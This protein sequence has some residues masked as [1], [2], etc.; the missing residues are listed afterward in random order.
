MRGGVSLIYMKFVHVFLTALACLAIFFVWSSPTQAAATLC[1]FRC[2]TIRT[3]TDAC[4]AGRADDGRIHTFVFGNTQGSNHA[5]VVECNTQCVNECD[6]VCSGGPLSGDT[7]LSALTRGSTYCIHGEVSPS[8]LPP[9]ACQSGA[10]VWRYP[11]CEDPPADAA[12]V[13]GH[14]TFTCVRG[15]QRTPYSG[16]AVACANDGDCASRCNGACG[17]GA[18]CLLATATPPPEPGALAHCVLPNATGASATPG[19][20]TTLDNPLHTTSISE[21]IA[22]VVR[23][24]TGIAGSMALLM[25]IVGGVMWMTA[26]G[27]DRV[28]MAQTILKNA[29]IGLVLIFLSYS[30]VS[31]FLAVLGL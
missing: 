16:E 10:P 27:S 9:A 1:R 7:P 21:L 28:G 15:T 25:F 13:G 17:D 3:P 30:I 11:W 5:T 6:R 8:V 24:L 4:L 2:A 31:L 22:R 26:E 12:P 19:S 14:C 18:T 29:S 20:P 23:A